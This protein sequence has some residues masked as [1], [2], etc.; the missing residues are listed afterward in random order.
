[1]QNS[2][3]FPYPDKICER[4]FNELKVAFD[5]NQR[6]TDAFEQLI[7]LSE[8]NDKKAIEFT[9]VDEIKPIVEVEI[10][11]QIDS[12]EFDDYDFPECPNVST[13]HK[14]FT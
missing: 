14:K 8:E 5:F 11:S 6:C 10:D 12:Q 4:C 2:I 7:K 13:S 1:M 9:S 3:Q